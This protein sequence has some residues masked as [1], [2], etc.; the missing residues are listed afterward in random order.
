MVLVCVAAAASA[1]TDAPSTK[2][3]YL[4]PTTTPTPI[5]SST[6]KPIISTLG[7]NSFNSFHSSLFPSISTYSSYG[8]RCLKNLINTYSVHESENASLSI[9]FENT[10]DTFNH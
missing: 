10:A 2:K 8:V 3:D 6:E 9:H 4:P 1:L 7:Q 5:S